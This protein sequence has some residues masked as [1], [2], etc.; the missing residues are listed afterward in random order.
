MFKMEK[1]M[2]P[3]SKGVV[4]ALFFI[5]TSFFLGIESCWAAS[6]TN[7]DFSA[8]TEIVSSSSLQTNLISGTTVGATVEPG[9]NNNSDLAAYNQR[10]TIWWKWTSPGRGD[11]EFTAYSQSASLMGGAFTGSTVSNLATFLTVKSDVFW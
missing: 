11:V 6:P 9:E 4:Q 2:N 10:G 8:A 3:T 1:G 7:D 5:I